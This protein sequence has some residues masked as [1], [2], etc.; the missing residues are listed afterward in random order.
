M[1]KSEKKLMKS[2]AKIAYEG[3]SDKAV[4]YALTSA[5]MRV[6]IDLVTKRGVGLHTVKESAELFR[7]G[8]KNLAAL[9]ILMH[10]K[11]LVSEYITDKGLEAM[12]KYK[13]ELSQ[14][15]E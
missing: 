11:E 2:A 8:C 4:Q 9:E 1:F 13:E 14:E 6:G 7:D 10:S 5:A 3:V 12:D 15:E